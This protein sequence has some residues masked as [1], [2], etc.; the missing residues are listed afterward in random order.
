M[1]VYLQIKWKT[2]KNVYSD[3][4]WEGANKFIWT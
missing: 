4:E 2:A 3:L 1:C